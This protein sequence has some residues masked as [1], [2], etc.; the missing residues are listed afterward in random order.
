VS[1]IVGARLA[2][3][4]ANIGEYAR[5]PISILYIHQGGL[6]FY[7]GFI[8]AAVG[9]ALFAL[10][11]R[12]KLLPLYDV[13]IVALPLSHALGRIG[14]FLNGCCFGK[15]TDF[16]LGVRYPLDSAVGGAQW[17]SG[18][19][20]NEHVRSLVG[21]LRY[22]KIDEARFQSALEELKRQGTISGGDTQCH[23]VHPVQLYEAALNV[24]LYLGLMWYFGRR[25]RDGS[26]AALYLMMYPVIRFSVEFLRGDERQKLLGLTVAQ[27]LSVALFATGVAAWVWLRNRERT[28]TGSSTE[29][30]I[31]AH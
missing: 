27:L 17:R 3:V 5:N 11:R 24:I 18:E 10:S 26:I 7:G 14:C 15:V 13:V 2:H 25:K 29:R 30:S 16:I 19:I 1:G 21:Q 12:D 23:P 28:H 22:S 31:R 4:V 6:I 9:I 8:G 20:G